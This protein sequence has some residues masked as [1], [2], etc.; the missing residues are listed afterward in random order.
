ML[1]RAMFFVLDELEDKTVEQ[2]VHQAKDLDKWRGHPRALEALAVRYMEDR[3][4]NKLAVQAFVHALGGEFD[5]YR[6]LAKDCILGALE[7]D[8]T[9]TKKET[10]QLI[11]SH[12]TDAI[13]KEPCQKARRA[14]LRLLADT[15][16]FDHDT[17][18]ARCIFDTDVETRRTA[19]NLYFGRVSFNMVQVLFSRLSDSNEDPWVRGLLSRA[20][21]N[22]AICNRDFTLA[23]HV[24]ES[25][26]H[27]MKYVD[28]SDPKLPENEDIKRMLGFMGRALKAL[29]TRLEKIY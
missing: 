27:A 8:R 20:L 2:L 3:G 5:C 6:T 25:I 19:A 26:M 1:K 9:T 17:A 7:F 15:P 13:D 28:S 18:L 4:K 12:V 29:G 16:D 22:Y 21:A 24:V 10:A 14:A 11:S 23:V